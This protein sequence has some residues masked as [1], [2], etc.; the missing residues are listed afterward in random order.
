MS[1]VVAADGTVSTAGGN[2][3][4]QLGSGGTLDSAVRVSA[5][6][7]TLVANAWLTTDSDSD[8]LS[9]WR[10]WLAGTDPLSSD[11]N[12]NGISDAIE[13]AAGR[14]ASS[15]DSDGDGVP[16]ELE[17]RQGTDPFVADTD[18]DGVNDGLDAFPLDPGRW[19]P[20]VADPNDVT[21]PVITL[22]APTNAR[23]I[24]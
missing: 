7:L 8:G 14:A 22:I 11:T 20:L 24:R 23:R 3:S 9:N 5:S 16:D 6:G 4:G 15:L 21:P 1:S 17:V 10:E 12:G 18:G 2:A 19:Q 13:V